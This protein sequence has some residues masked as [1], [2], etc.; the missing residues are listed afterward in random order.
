MTTAATNPTTAT[1]TATAATTNTT[2]TDVAITTATDSADATT[3][4]TP[5][6]LPLDL[7]QTQVLPDGD[8]Q[9]HRSILPGGVRVL[10]QHMP[11]TRAVALGFWVPTGSRDETPELAGASHFLEHLLFK[12]TH[13]RSALQIA[14]AFDQVG[15]DSNAAT[16]R[17]S[18][19]FWAQVLDEDAPMALEILAD[20][21]TSS[22]LRDEDVQIERGVILD[23]LAITD[24]S[25]GDLGHEV[26]QLLIHGD[27]GLGR[28]VGGTAESVAALPAAAIR[29]IYREKYLPN[30]LIFTAAG[31]VNH[32]QICEQLQQA[33]AELGVELAEGQAPAPRRAKVSEFSQPGT[34][35]EQVLR[36]PGEQAHVFVGG[37][38]LPALDPKGPAN[39]VFSTV[40]GGGMSSRLFQEVREKRGLAYTTY[41]FS[42]AFAD[43]GTFGLY[44]G[45]A[46]QNAQEVRK[47]LW[48]QAEEIAAHG[49]TQDELARTQ[50]QLVGSMFL[51]LEDSQS[52]MRRLGDAELRG[53]FIAT[54]TAVARTRGVTT[55]QVQELAQT[56]VESAR[57]EV[58]VLPKEAA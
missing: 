32:E 11:G 41:A 53:A 58:L 16:G 18:T 1:S 46:P 45:C 5:I 25:P 55:E 49:I 26:F 20:M 13:T 54:P 7:P 2:A 28:P 6:L 15:G 48:G 31:N 23:E 50:G 14:T 47:I 35:A 3:A 27:T 52:R 8:L 57:V 36:R 38:W 43:T 19:F 40:L 30:N 44:A 51:G 39:V 34:P 21:I 4:T 10:T 42:S 33:F 37:K 12:G 9:V 17:E 29:R 56:L 22:R 24:D